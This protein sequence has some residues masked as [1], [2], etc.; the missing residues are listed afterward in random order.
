MTKQATT[1]EAK[2]LKQTGNYRFG[3]R[4]VGVMN[5]WREEAGTMI[6]QISIFDPATKKDDELR[7]RVDDEIAI[8]PDRYRVMQIVEPQGKEYA[9]IEIAPIAAPS[10]QPN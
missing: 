4:Q 5:V 2:R 7:V 9:W 3:S 1:G 8:G 6:A 10:A